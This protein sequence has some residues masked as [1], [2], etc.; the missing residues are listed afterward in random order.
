MTEQ[1]NLTL[2]QTAKYLCISKSTL[3]KWNMARVIPYYKAGRICVYKQQDL[4][5][6]LSKNRVPCKSELQ[7][8]ALASLTNKHT[9]I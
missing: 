1:Q 9:N 6:Y 7:A 4:D 5:S 8:N 2:T 3:S